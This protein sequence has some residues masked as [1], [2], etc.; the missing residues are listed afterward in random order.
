MPSLSYKERTSVSSLSNGKCGEV[1]FCYQVGKRFY[2]LNCLFCPQICLQWDSFINHME[3]VHDDIDH[4]KQKD[5]C[6][7]DIVAKSRPTETCKEKIIVVNEVGTF[8]KVLWAYPS[9]EMSSIVMQ[10]H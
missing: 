10:E 5:H 1:T 4:L 8:L 9:E 6:D 2:A 7:V 3:E